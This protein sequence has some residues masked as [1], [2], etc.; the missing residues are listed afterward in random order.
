[1]VNTYAKDADGLSLLTTLTIPK[2]HGLKSCLSEKETQA[3][4]DSVYIRLAGYISV[5]TRTLQIEIEKDKL[6]DLLSLLQTKA[7]ERYVVK[8]DLVDK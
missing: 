4:S 5:E 6:F 1:M 2:Q 8:M 7:L 3:V